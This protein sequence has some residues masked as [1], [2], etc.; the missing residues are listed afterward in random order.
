ML[1]LAEY[2]NIPDE[3]ARGDRPVLSPPRI[4]GADFSAPSNRLP[5]TV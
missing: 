3:V 2:L 1:A 4:E 5:L